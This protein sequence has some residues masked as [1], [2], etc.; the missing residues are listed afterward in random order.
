MCCKEGSSARPKHLVGVKNEK[1]VKNIEKGVKPFDLTKNDIAMAIWFTSQYF[2]IY[3]ISHDEQDKQIFSFDEFSVGD[4]KAEDVIEIQRQS[5]DKLIES[6]GVKDK[7]T[8]LNQWFEHQF[9]AEKILLE[10]IN[11]QH[12]APPDEIRNLLKTENYPTNPNI[13]S[14]QKILLEFI[15]RKRDASSK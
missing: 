2:S 13:L 12:L 1:T 9:K 11:D 14:R 7:F 4:T 3:L 10:F 15:R 8:K 5:I 6:Q